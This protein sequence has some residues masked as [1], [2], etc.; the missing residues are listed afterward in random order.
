MLPFSSGRDLQR[1][2]IV[3]LTVF[4]APACTLTT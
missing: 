1:T 2:T 4:G 3:R